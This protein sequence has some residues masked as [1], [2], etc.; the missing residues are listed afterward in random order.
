MRFYNF[1]PELYNSNLLF[2][3]VILLNFTLVFY[4]IL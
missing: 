1:V 3:L 4:K 2:T